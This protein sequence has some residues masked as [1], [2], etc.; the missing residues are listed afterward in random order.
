ML[1]EEERA[2]AQLRKQFKEKWKLE[3]SSKL[4]DALRKEVHLYGALIRKYFKF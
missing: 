1:D 3:P 2:D 4:T